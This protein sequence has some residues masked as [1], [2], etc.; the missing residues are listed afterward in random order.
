[1]DYSPYPRVC[2]VHKSSC[3]GQTSKDVSYFTSPPAGASSAQAQC[4]MEISLLPGVCQVRLDFIDFRM[5]RMM[6]GTCPQTD[7]LRISTNVKN[8]QIP[9]STL[10]GTI[11]TDKVSS[12]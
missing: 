9:F 1:M 10:C 2:C 5:G 11:N 8:S 3:V 4:N 7:S 12:N 6:A